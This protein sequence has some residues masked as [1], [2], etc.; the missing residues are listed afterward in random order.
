MDFIPPGPLTGD[1]ISKSESHKRRDLICQKRDG[2]KSHVDFVEG[3]RLLQKSLA[4]LRSESESNQPHVSQRNPE[5][6]KESWL[7][8][9][10]K[11]SM[12]EKAEESL[13]KMEMT[14]EKVKLQFNKEET[15]TNILKVNGKERSKADTESRCFGG[16][17]DAATLAL[18]TR[19]HALHVLKAMGR[20][21]DNMKYVSQRRSL[22]ENA[23][24]CGTPQQKKR[25][26]QMKSRTSVSLPLN[27]DIPV[28]QSGV[29]VTSM[30]CGSTVVQKMNNFKVFIQRFGKEYTLEL[31]A[32]ESVHIV[33]AKIF[34]KDINISDLITRPVRAEPLV[35]MVTAR[36]EGARAEIRELDEL[37]S[38]YKIDW[39]PSTRN[40]LVDLQ[41]EGTELNIQLRLAVLPNYPI[42]WQR[43]I[44]LIDIQS[45][46]EIP[47]ETISAL[48][49]V[50]QSDELVGASM[51]QFVRRLN[52]EIVTRL[53]T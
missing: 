22:E 17:C 13:K 8:K 46:P 9:R 44:Q 41:V 14:Q 51:I 23:D 3:E 30:L 12:R 1:P 35:T 24:M 20:E 42:S 38:S 11:S 31:E 25:A 36:I 50:A 4:E 39:N 49:D 19:N 40:I 28:T 21:V 45:N 5:S 26:A 37:K 27:K 2:W 29:R 47:K 15:E 33:A 7:R 34:P 6:A 18:S 53:R 10:L 48:Q 32:D 43:A 52:S 16:Q